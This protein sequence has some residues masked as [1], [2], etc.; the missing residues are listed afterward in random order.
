MSG[1]AIA[2]YLLAQSAAVTAVVTAER[3]YVGDIP[4]GA[5]P[6]IGVRHVSGVERGTVAMSEASRFRTDRVQ[7]TVHART[8]QS[9]AEVLELIRT[10]LSPN[11]GSINGFDVDSILPDGEGPDFD[12]ASARIYERSRD[13]LVSWRT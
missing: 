8:Y 6:A 12:D 9:K 2:R 10:A 7:V 13:F 5:I 4:Q 3:I 1:A 11:S